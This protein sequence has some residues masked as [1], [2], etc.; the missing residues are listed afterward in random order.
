MTNEDVD[1]SS[2]MY[3]LTNSIPFIS[4]ITTYDLKRP[5]HCTFNCGR[6]LYQSS[7]QDTLQLSLI[8]PSL[9]QQTKP[10]INSDY[11]NVE[12]D[13]HQGEKKVISDATPSRT[14]NDGDTTEEHP[15]DFPTKFLLGVKVDVVVLSSDT[16][17]EA[18]KNVISWLRDLGATIMIPGVDNIDILQAKF[19]ISDGIN[20][21]SVTEVYAESE[22]IQT[23]I[24]WVSEVR[25]D[26]FSVFSPLV[27]YCCSP[28]SYPSSY[29]LSGIANSKSKFGLKIF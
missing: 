5:L 22:P 1:L 29:H 13:Y 28:N 17:D 24:P 6:L 23:D 9:N 11:I 14:S 10:S 27:L 21:P 4:Y 2:T 7:H 3:L 18:T 20:D 12:L 16:E 8:M 25:N 19:I 26:T 15:A